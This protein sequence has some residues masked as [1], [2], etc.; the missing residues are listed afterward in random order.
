[1]FGKI[2]HDVWTA[3]DQ[4]DNPA[5][6]EIRGQL[7]SMAEYRVGDLRNIASLLQDVQRGR[8]T[9][10]DYLNGWVIAASESVGVDVPTHRMLVD[11]LRPVERGDI[12]PAHENVKPLHDDVVALYGTGSR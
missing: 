9:E 6:S 5:W 7:N 3:A 12:P 11:H 1:V 10:I 8:R 4:I 2:P